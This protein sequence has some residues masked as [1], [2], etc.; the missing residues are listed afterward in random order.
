MTSCGGEGC[1]VWCSERHCLH[2]LSRH[3]Q[4][5]FFGDSH[6]DCHYFHEPF[7]RL[8]DNSC[9]IGVQHAPYSPSHTCQRFLLLWPD[10]SIIVGL[11]QIPDDGFV[12]A[13][14]Y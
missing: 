8:R 7:S 2:L 13:E 5:S 6:D 11:D 3:R 14:A 10:Y 4:A 9:V 12:F 1:L